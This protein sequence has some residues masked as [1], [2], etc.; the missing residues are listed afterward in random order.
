MLRFPLSILI[1]S[2]NS[3]TAIVET[4]AGCKLNR[5]P[6]VHKFVMNESHGAMSFEGVTRKFIPGQNP[7]LIFY[8]DDGTLI[9]RID[10]SEL[11]FESLINLLVNRG[12]KRKP[13]E[14]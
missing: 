12:Y 10:M 1:V 14:L 8:E 7:D 9:E 5:L 3:E 13:D 6:D 4:C 11:D 2:S